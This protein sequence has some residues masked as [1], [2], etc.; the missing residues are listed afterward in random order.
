VP[1]QKELS[2]SIISYSPTLIRKA[3]SFSELVRTLVL[4]HTVS[5]PTAI[6][7]FTFFFFA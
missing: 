7:I 3:V 6:F 1:V 2:K 5:H 4:D